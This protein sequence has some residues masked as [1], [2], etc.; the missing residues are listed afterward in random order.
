MR[1]FPTSAAC[2]DVPQASSTTRDRPGQRGRVEVDL[3][4]VHV[5]LLHRQP[6]DE[7]LLDR[8]RL[9]EDLLEHEV[10]VPGLL[11]HD[12]VPRDALRLARHRLPCR[13]E[14]PHAVGPQDGDLSVLEED[15][16]ARVRE[17]RR[18]VRGDEV[19]A[20][21]ESDDDRRAIAH[22]DDGARIGGGDD[23]QRE[24]AAQSRSARVTAACRPSSASSRPTRCATTSVSVSVRNVMPRAW[25]SLLQLEVVLDDPVVHEDDAAALVAMRVSVLLGGTAV[26]GPACVTDAVGAGQRPLA[27]ARPRGSP[28]CPRCVARRCRQARRQRCQPSRSRDTRAGG[29]LR[30]PPGRLPDDR[31]IR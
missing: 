29:A 5:T 17:D 9:L 24:Q 14:E 1:N 25:S 22:G 3:R 13:V 28:A 12:R 18:D 7:R 16:V 20:V 27:Q 11:G 6:T 8:P 30:A 19:L 31:R 26:R 23:D 15:H 4:Q 21:A 10:L 2:H